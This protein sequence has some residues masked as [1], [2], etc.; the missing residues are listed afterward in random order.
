MDC[1]I[2]LEEGVV[3]IFTNP[4]CKHSWCKE[5]HHKLVNINHTSCV[6]CR[7]PIKLQRRPI[8]YNSYIQWL[9]D[10]GEPVIRW[11]NKRHHKMFKYRQQW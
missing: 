9:L 3:S 4:S 11:R 8:P 6:I 7:E 2:C 1:P 5:C 10:G